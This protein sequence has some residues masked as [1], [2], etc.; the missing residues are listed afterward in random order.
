MFWEYFILWTTQNC[1][2]CYIWEILHHVEF[3]MLYFIS[4]VFNVYDSHEGTCT[5]EKNVLDS[6]SIILLLYELILVFCY[7]K[8][9]TG[10]SEKNAL[11]LCII[12]YFRRCN[13]KK[14]RHVIHH[15]KAKGV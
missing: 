10:K 15:W 1:S 13:I 8:C 11:F 9:Y 7:K 4:V 6:P 5:Y 3:L 2:K 12:N 14:H